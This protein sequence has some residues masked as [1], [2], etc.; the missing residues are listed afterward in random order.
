MLFY[1][2]IKIFVEI[3]YRQIYNFIIL[4][5]IT[6]NKNKNIIM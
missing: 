6:T 1:N 2:T 4:H 3:K 5:S